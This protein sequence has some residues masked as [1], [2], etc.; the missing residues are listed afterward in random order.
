ME[1][2]RIDKWL[3]SVRIF[4]SRS[5]ATQACKS[6]KIRVNGSKC[7]PARTVMVDNLISVD[8]KGLK[9]EFKI[10]ELLKSR[11]GFSI[12][13]D[14]YEDLTSL[15]E[16]EKFRAFHG[17]RLSGEDREIGLGRPTKRDRRELEDFKDDVWED[18]DWSYD[19]GDEM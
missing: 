18:Q 7:K 2:V 15:E 14:C 4:K 16:R 5:I 10:L 6:G 12:A 13:K 1:K 8:K 17:R 3:W 9:L 19:M 11:V